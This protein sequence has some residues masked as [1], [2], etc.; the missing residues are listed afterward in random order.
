MKKFLILTIPML[1]NFIQWIAG[2]MSRNLFDGR[3]SGG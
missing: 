2:G 3:R 1:P